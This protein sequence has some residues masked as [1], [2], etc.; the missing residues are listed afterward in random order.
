MN[1]T[2]R[3]GS[4]KIDL[5]RKQRELLSKKINEL[6]L[7]IHGTCLEEQ[8]NE[9]YL[10]L[11][12]AGIS[13]RPKTYLSDEWGCP[14]GVPVIGIP[15]YLADSGLCKLEGK[16][17]GVETETSAEIL[18]YLRHEAGHAF[19]YAYQ[20]YQNKKWQQLFGAFSSPYQEVYKPIPFSARFV[21]HIPGWY[22]QKH[23]DEDFAETFA[24]W[25]SPGSEWRIKYA[26]TPALAK[27]LYVDRVARLYGRKPAVVTDE[28]MDKPVEEMTMTL[29]DWYE[30]NR[31]SADR[32]IKLHHIIDQDLHRLFPDAEGQQA[33]DV[34]QFYRLH[35]IRD[36]NHWTGIDRHI[37]ASLFVELTT[38]IRSLDLK[39]ALN[40]TANRMASAAIFITTLVM[41]FQFRGEFID[42]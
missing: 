11:E 4:N 21:H 39:I 1:K 41:N 3:E 13:F 30:T 31:R 10:E 32:A 19:N 15:F 6:A 24:V 25:L 38:R 42:S 36:V 40:Q 22:A 20:L 23:P 34:L 7:V 16:L 28:K 37:L 27:L 35:L 5:D 26:D 9:L 33:A 14:H 12:K 8:I 17:T 2:F 29:D 18:M